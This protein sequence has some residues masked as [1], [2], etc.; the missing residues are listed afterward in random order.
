VLIVADLAALITDLADASVEVPGGL[1]GTPD[2][3]VNHS[4]AVVNRGTPGF[5][6]AP[7]GTLHVSLMR[8]CSG[9]P[10]G[11]WIDGERRTAPDGS[12]FA[13]QHWSHT[14]D[15]SL[16]SGAGDWRE[17]GFTHAGQDVNHPVHARQVPSAPGDLPAELS[18]ITV[19][20]PEVLLTAA[21]PA[22]NPLASRVTADGVTVR[23]YEA[24][25]TPVTATVGLHGGVSAA[26]RTDVLEE[27]SSGPLAVRKGA[28]EVELTAADVATLRL[29]PSDRTD[30]EVLLARVQ[31]PVQPVFT[32]YWRHNAGPAPLGNLPTS[33]HINPPRLHLAPGDTA[34][35]RVTVSCSGQ[36][37]A[38]VVELSIPSGLAAELPARLNYDLAPDGFAEFVLTV[39]GMEPG[40]WLLAARIRD[41][42]G[43]VLEDT[44][45]I[46]VGDPPID[47]LV[48][49]RLD[50]EALALTVGQSVELPVLVRNNAQ[51]EIRG[52][53]TLISPHGTWSDDVRFGP[54]TQP[55]TIAA[56][57]TASISFTAHTASTARVGSHWWALV[58]VVGHGRVWYTPA[59]AVHVVE[60]SV[61]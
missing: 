58:R 51:S 19:S 43:Q 14:F 59:V 18:L 27:R 48:T 20:P 54:R 9:W 3:A 24:S 11:V 39:R 46:V 55:F 41:D 17:A 33:V 53:A 35:V 44:S 16:V 6:V 26:C 25:G 28:A 49:V 36:P 5:V 21:K 52:E 31:E 32:R 57:G 7:D 60:A 30:S 4:V 15:L 10:C 50:T 29:T 40:R 12:S 22:G 45:E 56:G 37:A 2:P 47:D 61:R 42:L 38:G 23:I 8:S 34:E 13:W 1:A